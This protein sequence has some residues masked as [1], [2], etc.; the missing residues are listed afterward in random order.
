MVDG[1]YSQAGGVE[2]VSHER[3]GC[4]GCG[5]II[6]A[7][8]VVCP[9]CGI[10]VRNLTVQGVA[11]QNP[12]DKTIAIILA[13]FVGMFTWVYTYKVDSGKFWINFIVSIVT[14]GIWGLVAWLWAI[15]EAASRSEQFYR[16]F[17]NG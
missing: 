16:N 8:V 17:P 1:N 9:S 5:K 11:A 12:K 2:H 14:V 7:D 4:P 13:I 15:I 10:Q 3:A 6:G